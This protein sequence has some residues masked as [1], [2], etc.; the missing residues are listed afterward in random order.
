MNRTPE[1]S[2]PAAVIV[3]GVEPVVVTAKENRAP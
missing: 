2:R 1:G 3:G